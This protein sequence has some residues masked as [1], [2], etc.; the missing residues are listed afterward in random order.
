[1]KRTLLFH[2]RNCRVLTIISQYHC[3][4]LQICRLRHSRSN[5]VGDNLMQE[6]STYD[7]ISSP[8]IP[9]MARAKYEFRYVYFSM[10]NQE[11]HEIA[12]YLL[13]GNFPS[14]YRTR[15]PL[16]LV[17]VTES[18]WLNHRWWIR[19]WLL[20]GAF[21]RTETATEESQSNM[22]ISRERRN[23]NSN[24]KVAYESILDI[25]ICCMLE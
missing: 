1:M 18:A 8:R 5:Y 4:N 23:W 13:S 17:N 15:K 10:K 2:Y 14:I 22:L 16:F 24:A 3:F 19:L 12:I 7:G 25:Q 21:F 11:S 20:V 6:F 9:R